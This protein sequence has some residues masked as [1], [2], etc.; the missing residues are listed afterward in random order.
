MARIGAG[1]AS[2]VEIALKS[3][4]NAREAQP[5]KSM[6]YGLQ[7]LGGA[8]G[9]T[10]R[11]VE[12]TAAEE[13]VGT[14]YF[15]LHMLPADPEKAAPQ[16]TRIGNALKAQK[17]RHVEGWIG[18]SSYVFGH[19]RK[20]RLET[21]LASLAVAAGIVENVRPHFAAISRGG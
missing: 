5:L 9:S 21:A 19:L 15:I 17:P 10:E 13:I 14:A 7:A 6:Q 4:Y 8:M 1:R 3:R 12:S 16:L 11:D 2:T 20:Q 18:Q